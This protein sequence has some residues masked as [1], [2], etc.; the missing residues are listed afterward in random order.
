MNE[1][2]TTKIN[3]LMD[4][5][6]NRL[7]FDVKNQPPDHLPAITNAIVI[8]YGFKSGMLKGDERHFLEMNLIKNVNNQIRSFQQGQEGN[9]N[10][11][12]TQSQ[13]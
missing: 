2:Q 8:L 5:I 6:L 3:Q 1:D 12:G 13:R 11:S 10:G 4:E 7:D 9:Q